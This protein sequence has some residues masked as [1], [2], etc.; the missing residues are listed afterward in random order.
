MSLTWSSNMFSTSREPRYSI[1]VVWLRRLRPEDIVKGTSQWKGI[2]VTVKLTI[3]NRQ[4]KVRQ[5]M[6]DFLVTHKKRKIC[7]F[8]RITML[9]LIDIL[10]IY[11][12]IACFLKEKYYRDSTI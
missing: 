2:R 5:E 1:S 6:G 12:D 3:Q 7:L 4:A 9:F 8:K 10:Y 11:I